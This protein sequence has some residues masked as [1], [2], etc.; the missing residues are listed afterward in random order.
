LYFCI[1][2]NLAVGLFGGMGIVAYRRG[3]E[4]TRLLA[5]LYCYGVLAFSLVGLKLFA[6]AVTLYRGWSGVYLYAGIVI[7]GYIAWLFFALWW[8]AGN[9]KTLTESVRPDP[10]RG[11][12]PP[13]PED[14]TPV[15]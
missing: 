2:A 3:D 6:Y 13:G 1:A 7:A 15:V 4:L 12:L 8:P 14:W 11:A 5:R 10:G 9:Y